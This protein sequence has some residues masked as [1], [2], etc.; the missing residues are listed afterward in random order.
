MVKGGSS[1]GCVAPARRISRKA[2]RK[3]SSAGGPAYLRNGDGESPVTARGRKV[4][5]RW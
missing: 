1:S 4:G 5:A 2:E 3:S